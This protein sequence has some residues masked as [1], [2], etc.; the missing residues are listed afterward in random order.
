MFLEIIPSSETAMVK[1]I[2]EVAPKPEVEYELR[3]VVWHCDD[4][5]TMDVEDCSDLFVTAKVGEESQQT[6]VHYRS[7]DGNGSFNYRMIFPV[8]LPMK[9]P[10]ITFAI[11]DKDILSPSDFISEGSLSF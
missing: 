8:T 4:C 11:W 7:Q 3:A 5:P 10:S 2:W 9:D 6:D 1:E